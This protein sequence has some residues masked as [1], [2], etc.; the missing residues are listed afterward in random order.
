MN[1]INLS[2]PPLKLFSIWKT[3]ICI[4][5]LFFWEIWHHCHN[6]LIIHSTRSFQKK[7]NHLL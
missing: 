1:E 2:D 7:K 4:L 5:L 3:W 6:T